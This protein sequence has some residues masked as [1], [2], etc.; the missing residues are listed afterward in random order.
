MGIFVNAKECKKNARV[1]TE[2]FPGELLKPM[3]K[4]VNLPPEV[5]TLLVNYYYNIYGYSFIILLN[6]HNSSTESIVVL[7]KVNQ[8]ERL[9]LRA[10]IF[11][12]TFSKWYI[13]SANVLAQFILDDNT[14]NTYSG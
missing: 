14:T 3:K 5:L 1:G 2:H 6:I 9:R 13:K 8:F 12:S 10:K 11:G 7:P 4:D